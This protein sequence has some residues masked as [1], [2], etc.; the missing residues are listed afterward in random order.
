MCS[1]PLPWARQ[2]QQPVDD[3]GLQGVCP[4][5]AQPSEQGAH[6][7]GADPV[8]TGGRTEGCSRQRE[9]PGQRSGGLLEC[10]WEGEHLRKARR[11]RGRFRTQS[12]PGQWGAIRGSGA[13]Q[14]PQVLPF[15]TSLAPSLFSVP[16][17][18]WWWPIRPRSSTRRPTG[19]AT[20]S[21]M[22]PPLP[23]T[24]LTLAQLSGLARGPSV[25][26]LFNPWSRETTL[27]FLWPEKPCRS[28]GLGLHPRQGGGGWPG[29]GADPCGGSLAVCPVTRLR[30]RH[31]LALC[32]LPDERFDA[33]DPL[34][35]ATATVP[36]SQMRKQALRECLPFLRC[37]P[38]LFGGEVGI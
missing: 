36:M 11:E 37:L 20:T 30:S 6:R 12:T 16:G 13:G 26:D 33:Y 23:H 29:S 4:R 1:V 22:S 32:P 31:L 7:P 38:Q 8:S 2:V 18:W 35:A 10:V 25:R 28:G 3:R 34:P 21:R 17:A 27:P 19:P 15:L 5:R 9:L 24:R 14:R